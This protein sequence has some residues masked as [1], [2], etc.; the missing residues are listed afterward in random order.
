MH[1]LS[2]YCVP[3]TG[4]SLVKVGWVGTSLHIQQAQDKIRNNYEI[5]LHVIIIHVKIIHLLCIHRILGDQ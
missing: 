4:L 1:L 5:Q 2:T 3:S